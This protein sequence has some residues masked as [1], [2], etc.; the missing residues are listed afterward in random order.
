[1]DHPMDDL[2]KWTHEDEMPDIDHAKEHMKKLIEILYA[3]GDLS[4]LDYHLEEICSVLSMSLPN[5][6]LKVTKESSNERSST[7]L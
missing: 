2:Y 6:E 1:M 3:N 4:S 5:S 7:I